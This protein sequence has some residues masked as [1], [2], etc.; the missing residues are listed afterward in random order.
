MI[1][2]IREQP[3]RQIAATQPLPCFHMFGFA[4]QVVQPLYGSMI[5]ALYPPIATTRESQPIQPTPQNVIDH[6]RR[7]KCTG[8]FAIPAW[9]QIWAQD[10]QTVDFLASLDFV[11]RPIPPKIYPK[12]IIYH[13]PGLLW[14]TSTNQSWRWFNSGRGSYYTNLRRNR[15]WDTK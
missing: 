14:W 2:D 8:M 15:N 13:S 5:S 3:Y 4:T 7:T 9:L 12:S 1:T 11:V 6:S 10:T